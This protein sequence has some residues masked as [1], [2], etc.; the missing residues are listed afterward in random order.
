VANTFPDVEGG[1]RTYLR[2][3]A[4]V[5][6]IVGSRVFF[7]IPKGATESTFPLV[8]VAR[9]G[10][11]SD[12]SDAPVDLALVSVDCWGTIDDSGH[13]DKAGATALVN[14]VRSALERMNG[15]TQ[16]SGSMYGFGVQEAGVVWSPDPDNDR[17]HYALTAEVSAILIP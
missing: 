14:S 8:T 13:G 11:G 6:A 2:N 3:D 12:T 10:G 9:I 16:L 15:P 4:D 1:I 5:A 17:P 7:G